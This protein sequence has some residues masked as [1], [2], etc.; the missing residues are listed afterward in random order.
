M[1]SKVGVEKTAAGL[2]SALDDLEEIRLD[3]LPRMRLASQARTAN[4]EWLDAVD[5]VN[6]LVAC[7]LIVRSSLERKESRGPFFRRDYPQMDNAHWLAANVLRKTDNGFRFEQRPYD[8]AFF[9]PDFMEK[10]NLE[11]AW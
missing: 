10:D 6:M 5:L 9:K 3:L 1:W 11:V 7:E 8:L 2:R 4:Y